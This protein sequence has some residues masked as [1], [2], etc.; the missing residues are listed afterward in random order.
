MEKAGPR[1]TTYF[2]LVAESLRLTIGEPRQIRRAEAFAHLLEKVDLAILPGEPL[3]GSISGMWPPVEAPLTY[4]EIR[5]VAEECLTEYKRLLTQSGKDSGI[6]R[7]GGMFTTASGMGEGRRPGIPRSVPEP[8]ADRKQNDQEKRDGDETK[9]ESRWVLIARD[10][11]DASIPYEDLQRVIK[12][13]QHEYAD[14]PVLSPLD[15]ARE[16]ERRFVFDYGEETRRLF[17]DLPWSVANHLH[18]DYGTLIRIGFGG[19]LKEIETGT[20]KHS[21]AHDRLQFYEAATIAISGAIQFIRR[22][23]RRAAEE[24]TRTDMDPGRRTELL[25]IAQRLERIAEG[26]PATFQDGIQLVWLCHLIANIGGGS[27]MSF[28]RFDQYLYPLYKQGIDDGTV[29]EEEAERLIACLWLKV[30]EPKMRTV[31]SMTLGGTDG[32]GND[33]SNE[34]TRL[35]LKVCAEMRLPYPNTALRIHA[36]TP[37][38]LYDLALESIQS[39]SGNPMFLNDDSWIPVL[40]KRGI[41]R[42]ETSEYYNMGCVEIMI[43]AKQAF[44][45]GAGGISF[46]RLLVETIGDT[47]GPF[48]SFEDLMTSYSERITSVIASAKRNAESY[49]ADCR[50]RRYDPFASCLVEGCLEQGKDLYQGGAAL[51]GCFP[52]GGA[53]LGTAADSLSAIKTLVFDEGTVE[54][55]QLEAAVASNFEGSERLRRLLQARTPCFG[56]DIDPVDRIAARILQTYTDAVAELND[57]SVPGVFVASVFSYTSQVTQGEVVGATPNGR[58]SGAPLSDNA[59]PS[60]GMDT[61]GP[62]RL[63]NSMGKLNLTGITGAYAMNLKVDSGILNDMEGY[64]AFKQ[65]MKTYF[66]NGSRC[67]GLQL[68]LNYV[69]Q[70]ILRAAQEHP[71]LHSELIVR[72]AGFSEYF[73]RLDRSLQDEIISRSTHRELA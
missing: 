17:E 8:T 70:D 49:I 27:A 16:L 12:E 67:G 24:A 43:G 50:G 57:G 6:D 23:S 65:L 71:E 31:Q 39:G 26:V 38:E 13:K 34:L 63:L 44:W 1:R 22:Y 35:C 30:N 48:E 68:Q 5:R 55:R 73:N 54:W 46:P 58:L 42:E 32:H 64:E 19:I 4:P 20:R 59:G 36:Q 66:R 25:E 9:S 14:D 11:F 28:A 52:V 61:G 33:L 3:V 41:S 51:P 45:H 56:N 7:W 47:A 72:V 29:T 60:Q 62:T 10:H 37:E 40:M 18:L 69:D 53:G 15:I 21:D 2:D